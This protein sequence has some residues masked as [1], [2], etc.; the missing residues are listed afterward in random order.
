MQ[1]FR[2]LAIVVDST[3]TIELSAPEEVR[4]CFLAIL[5][6]KRADASKTME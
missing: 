3:E 5:V 2:S 6:K 1:S 4:L